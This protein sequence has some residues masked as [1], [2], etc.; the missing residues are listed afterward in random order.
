M[1]R[2][3]KKT[4]IF[5]LSLIVAVGCFY[6]SYIYAENIETQDSAEN[7]V[8]VEEAEVSATLPADHQFTTL[9]RDGNVVP[10]DTSDKTIEQP[11]KKMRGASSYEVTEIQGDTEITLQSFSS[12][13]E[14]TDF[15]EDKKEN[16]NLK[17][18]ALLED[19]I[20]R[21]I[22]YGVVNFRT[23]NCSVNTL[24]TET[25]TNRSG[26]TNGCY[27][28]DGAY[29]ATEGSRVKFMQSGV[30]GYVNASDVQILNY[31]SSAV[32]SVNFYR[33]EGGRIIHYSTTDVSGSYY[34][35]QLDIGPQQPYM[36]NNTVYYSYDGHYFYTDYYKMID[37]YKAGTFN[38]SINP[39]K[40]YY[41]YFQFL[42]HR[43]STNISA[44]TMNTR[45]NAY[46]SSGKMANTGSSFITRQSAYGSNAALMFGVAANESAWGTSNIAKTKN[47]LFGHSAYDMNPNSANKYDNVDMSIY[48]HA[49]KFISQDYL[50]PCDGYNTQ[51]N[52]YGGSCGTGRYYGPHLGDKASGI[53]VKYAS[54]PYWGEKAAAQVYALDKLNGNKDYG[55]YVIGVMTNKNT[56]VVIRR[57]ADSKSALLY[58]TGTT[59]NMPFIIA[60]TRTGETINGSNVWYIIQ[61]DPTLDASRMKLTQDVGNYSY[62]NYY[63]Y[64]HSSQVN[65]VHGSPTLPEEPTSPENPS[66]PP[67]GEI[68]SGDVNGDG[69]ATAAD[70]LMIKD[71]IMGKIKLNADQQKAADVT[72]DGKVS[73]ADYLKIK[74][75]IMGKITKL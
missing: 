37:N 67:V 3:L 29:I 4:Q 25:G 23:K 35:I 50:D 74:D 57:Y 31:D 38:K 26:Y 14:A 51:G 45:V 43:T 71:H 53:N 75:Y 61:S 54:D 6:G 69:K 1:L 19:G 42:S 58:R 24:Y 55:R 52:G 9:D 56:N 21:A 66:K 44:A 36:N 39:T 28:A 65:I 64:V 63:A 5:I 16:N 68:V 22:T 40:P 48:V 13:S 59:G 41:N 72:N 27:G 18:Y 73:A 70:Y 34:A 62:G 32:K 12:F 46:A 7:S 33:A 15:F 2:K 10:L 11:K 49:K 47:N 8:D 17:N 60:G 20:I 30:V